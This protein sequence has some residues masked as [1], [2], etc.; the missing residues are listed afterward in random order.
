M[1]KSIVIVGCKL[2]SGL[3]I[4]VGDASVVLNGA[5]SNTVVDDTGFGITKVDGEFWEA[6]KKGHHDFTPLVNGLIFAH[7]DQAKTRSQAKENAKELTGLEGID[8]KKPGK[9]GEAIEPA[10]TKED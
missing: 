5:N 10:S 7:D 2:P 4:R 9:P 8:P 6:W 1:A 3:E